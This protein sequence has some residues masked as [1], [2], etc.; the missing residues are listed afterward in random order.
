[1]KELYPRLREAAILLGQGF[2]NKEIAVKMGIAEVTLKR[3]LII[4]YEF[5]KLQDWGNSRV[6]LALI[7]STWDK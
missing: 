3:Y 4:T 7:S 1:M 2:S 6:R 5:Y